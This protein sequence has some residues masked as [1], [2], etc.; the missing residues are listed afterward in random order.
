MVRLIPVAFVLIVVSAPAYASGRTVPTYAKDVAPILNRN[1]VSCHRPGQIA[2]MSLMSYEEVRPWVKSIEKNVRLGE[3]PPWHADPAHS[4]FANDRSLSEAEKGTLLEW[5]RNGAPRGN[6]ADLPK[7]PTFDDSEWT[8]GEP[9]FVVEFKP[10]EVPAEG[11]DLFPKV[12]GKAELPEDK[13]IQAVEILPGDRRVVHHAIVLQFKG[14][15]VDPEDGWLAAWAAGTEPMVFP[16]GTGR[17]LKKGSNLIADMHYHPCGEPVTD[18]TRVGLHFADEDEVEKEL[19]NLWVANYDFRI[20]A[21]AANHEVRSSYTFL[22]DAKIHAFAP[23]MHYRGKDFTY[24]AH[25]PDGRTETLLKVADYD[26]NWQTNYVLKE[27]IPV[28]ERTTIECIA[29]Y[30]NSADN[31]ANPD[32]TQELTFGESTNDEMMIGF[33]D[34]VVVDGV[35]PETREET[36]AR[37]VRELAAAYPGDVYAVYNDRPHDPT[38]LHLPKTGEGVIAL[39]VNGS[40]RM[41]EIHD[42]VWE[43]NTFTAKVDLGGAGTADVSGSIDP[44]RGTVNT[45]IVFRETRIPLQGKVVKAT[46]RAEQTG[47]SGAQ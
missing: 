43:G 42:I 21:G 5:A 27:A 19:V 22:Q 28:P 6:P 1:C 46:T 23:H 34:Y 26:F 4:E 29:H 32:P 40:L 11:P 20:P 14:F 15:D 35:R 13:W 8:L 7:P 2:P 18:V 16:E 25:Y 31:P 12:I 33:V 10:V 9:D 44:G 39:G 38:P 45:E 30:D 24:L 37:K 41:C 17:F 47:R 3:M 36:R